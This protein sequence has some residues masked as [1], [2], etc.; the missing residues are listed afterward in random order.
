M[1]KD[2]P[3]VGDVWVFKSLDIKVRII[4]A[5]EQT[6]EYIYYSPCIDFIKKNS[7]DFKDFIKLYKYLGKSKA[8]INDLFKTDNEE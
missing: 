8:N 7:T 3:E 5:D 4:Y 1:S 6:I 2:T